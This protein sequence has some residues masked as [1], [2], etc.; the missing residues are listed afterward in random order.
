MATARSARSRCGPRGRQCLRYHR[1]DDREPHGG[2]GQPGDKPSMCARPNHFSDPDKN[3]WII[4]PRDER[5][6]S[7]LKIPSTL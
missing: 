4:L 3:H 5:S 6:S 1:H 2:H 7:H